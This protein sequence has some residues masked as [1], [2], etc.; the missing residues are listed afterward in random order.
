VIIRPTW[1]K[2]GLFAALCALLVAALV[3]AGFMPAATAKGAALVV[4]TGHGPVVLDNH[5]REVPSPAGKASDH[6]VC[7]F[8]GHGAVLAGPQGAAQAEV[9]LVAYAPYLPPSV[10]AAPGRGLSAPPPPSHAPP[11]L[12]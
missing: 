1:R 7:A 12:I 11:V 8:A 2:L 3:P 6:Q 9:S 10:E 4:C 5:A